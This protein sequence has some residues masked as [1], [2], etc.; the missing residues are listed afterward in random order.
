[1]RCNND[2]L[3]YV[4]LYDDFLGYISDK[5]DLQ[6]T[7][8][9]RTITQKADWWNDVMAASY[10]SA[11]RHTIMS[12]EELGGPISADGKDMATNPAWDLPMLGWTFEVHPAFLLY[13]STSPWVLVLKNPLDSMVDS[14]CQDYSTML[15]YQ[16]SFQK[17]LSVDRI[18]AL[19]TDI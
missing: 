7:K 18:P 15:H 1:M 8:N 10:T 13:H 14:A 16:P 5:F 17:L 9:A 12:G 6:F 19:M 3:S 2:G 4:I 11:F